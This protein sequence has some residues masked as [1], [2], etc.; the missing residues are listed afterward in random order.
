MKHKEFLAQQLQETERILSTV[1][2]ENAKNS[3]YKNY[4]KC[5][6]I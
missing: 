3:E 5:N 6:E 2:I 1:T 4:R